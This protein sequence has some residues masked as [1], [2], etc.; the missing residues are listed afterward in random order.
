MYCKANLTSYIYYCNKECLFIFRERESKEQES[1][2]VKVGLGSLAGDR[3]RVW[4]LGY[5][6]DYGKFFCIIHNNNI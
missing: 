2:N 6:Q 1:Q 5:T 4:P 3:N